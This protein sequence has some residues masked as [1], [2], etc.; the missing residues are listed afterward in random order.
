MINEIQLMDWYFAFRQTCILNEFNRFY[1]IGRFSGSGGYAS[2]KKAKR[3]SD[4]KDFAVKIFN[5]KI[6]DKL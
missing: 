2:I 6:I 3:M 1:K 5:K 4:K